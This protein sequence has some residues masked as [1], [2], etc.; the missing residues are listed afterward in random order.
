VTLVT[1]ERLRMLRW[2]GLRVGVGL[3]VYVVAFYLSFPFE[4]IKDQVTALAAQKDLDVDIGWAG[5]LFGVGVAFHDIAVSKHASDT[6]KKAR[7]LRIDEARVR[8]SPLARL[9]GET[10]VNLSADALGGGVNVDYTGSM[11]KNHVKVKGEDLSL[12]QVPGVKEAINLPLAGKMGLG[13]DLTMTGRMGETGGHVAWN[14]DGCA[15]GDGKSK[16]KIAGVLDEGLDLPRIRLGNFAG[17]VVFD[18]GVGKLQAVQARS[19]DGEFSVDGEIRLADPIQYSQLDL[20]VRF[21]LSDAL[22]K[23]S[24]KL[25]LMMQLVEGMGK[26]P[27]GAYGLRLTGTFARIA[28]P[29]W[30]KTSP[31]SGPGHG[32]TPSSLSAPRRSG[33]GGS[34][35]GGDPSRPPSP[36]FTPPPPPPV[37]TESV[38]PPTLA[39]APTPPPTLAPAPTT[40][41]P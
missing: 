3:V 4:R 36:G 24:D 5:P 31:F 34:R 16:L 2:I 29:Q 28:P 27:D 15:I 33:F 13:I 41:T 1:P 8:V 12:T 14:C 35:L 17:R 11:T 19:P 6:A 26:G 7:P 23:S 20:Y 39:P 30:T 32:G 21:K 25:G 40:A 37:P 22:L 38:P 18:K 10:S 9:F